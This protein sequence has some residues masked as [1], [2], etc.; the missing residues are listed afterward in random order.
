[1][2]AA[3]SDPPGRTA[4]SEAGL[5]LSALQLHRLDANLENLGFTILGF[6]FVSDV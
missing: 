4:R 6:G 5:Q 1:M 3:R 2:H